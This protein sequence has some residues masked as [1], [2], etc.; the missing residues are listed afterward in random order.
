MKPQTKRLLDLA[1]MTAALQLMVLHDYR[2][3][4]NSSPLIESAE[5][6][7][8]VCLLRELFP[9]LNDVNRYIKSVMDGE[10]TE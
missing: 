10:S 5:F 3:A 4:K 6:K 7:E 8:L 9:E 1:S 2:S